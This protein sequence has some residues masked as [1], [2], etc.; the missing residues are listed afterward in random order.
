AETAVAILRDEP[1]TAERARV[2]AGYGQMLMLLD[3]WSESRAVCEEAI[4]IALRVGAREAEGH[5]RNSL[6]LDLAAQGRCEEALESLETAIVIAEEVGNADDVGRAH[7]NLAEALNVC[8]L[9]HEAADA[10]VRGIAAAEAYG[11]SSSY[12]SFI[13]HN[14]ILINYDLGRWETAVRLAGESATSLS[15]SGASN[16]DRYLASHWAPLL[17]ATGQFEQ[18]RAQLERLGELLEGAPLEAQFSGNYVIGRAELALWEGRTLDALAEVDRGLAWLGDEGWRWFV[19]RLL[20]LGARAAAD[21]VGLARARRDPAGEA[22]ALARAD[23]YRERRVR[24]RGACEAAEHGPQLAV[25]LAEFAMAEAEDTRPD[26]GGDVA[27]WL[28][29]RDQWLAL[30]R[31]YVAAYASWRLGEAR[32]EAGDRDGAATDLRDAHATATG[33]GALPLT[34]AIE[35]LAARARIDLRPASE[36]SLPPTQADPFGLTRR[37]REVLALVATGR[38]NRQIA[39]ELFISENT[40]G[41]HV[42]NILGKLG[43]ASRT[44]AAAVAV[45]LDMGAAPEAG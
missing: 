33:L 39:D 2:L 8:G 21:A 17:V 30:E 12:G 15:E 16:P 23:A 18:A 40:A 3:H 29:V 38:T 44:E 14:G 5:A 35:A 37:E 1:P 36:A 4:E 45:R 6:G 34:T 19:T 9:V 41:V 7:V 25:S 10:V 27:S 22:E 13:R 28:D 32:L 11:I 24:H 20:R 26:G 42:S 31:P 43:V